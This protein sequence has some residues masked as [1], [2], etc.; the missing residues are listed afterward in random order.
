[1]YVCNTYVY[2][3]IIHIVYAYMLVLI[4]EVAGSIVRA[5]VA[6]MLTGAI[7]VGL[8]ILKRFKV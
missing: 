7:L 4:I 8:L 5:W 6:L 3:H 2:A 1:M